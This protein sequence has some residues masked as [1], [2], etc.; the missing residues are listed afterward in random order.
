MKMRTMW[1]I[2]ADMRNQ[3]YDLPD[4]VVKTSYSFN[5]STDWDLY[6]PYRAW[7]IDSHTKVSKLQFFMIICP[8]SSHLSV[9]RPQLYRHLRTRS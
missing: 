9:S 7:Q 4:E 6:L 1:R 2:R 8:I 5:Y 3:V